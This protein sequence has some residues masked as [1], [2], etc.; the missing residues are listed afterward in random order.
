[1]RLAPV[2]QEATDTKPVA[3]DPDHGYPYLY[4]LTGKH[5][6]FSTI[7]PDEPEGEYNYAN[8]IDAE[9]KAREIGGV[10]SLIN[11]Y[12][13]VSHPDRRYVGTCRWHEERG[14]T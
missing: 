5:P 11:T 1:M 2:T 10:V 14:L 9:A 3:V 8:P 6:A 12:Y 13:H 4:T 7:Y